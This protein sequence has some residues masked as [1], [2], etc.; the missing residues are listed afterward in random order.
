VAIT[1]AGTHSVYPWRDGQ[2]ELAW[3]TG[4]AAIQFTCLKAVTHPTTNGAQCRAI[5]LIETN[6][7]V[8]VT[9]TLNCHTYRY[10]LK[11]LSPSLSSL[12]AISPGG[13]GLA[14]TRMSP[15]GMLLGLRMMKVL[16][17]A[18]V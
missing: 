4:Y 3:M 2:A 5:L 17:T 16:V 14:G 8:T 12:T 13:H 7:F 9:A 1:I 10:A 15:F 6:V 11:Q 18:G